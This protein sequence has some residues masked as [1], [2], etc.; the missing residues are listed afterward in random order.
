MARN[1]ISF[2]A[3]YKDGFYFSFDYNN[4]DILVCKSGSFIFKASPCN[5]V[6]KSFV[7]VGN[8]NN[9]MLNVGSSNSNVSDESCL[10][11]YISSQEWGKTIAKLQKDGI[12]ESFNLELNDVCE[13]CSLGNMTKAPFT[14]KFKP[15]KDLLE[16]IHT[17][18][19][20][21]SNLV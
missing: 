7:C 1:I 16:L 12:L 2:H 14:G 5:G 11:H 17:N 10:W 18:N 4:G 20:D 9:L 15:G 8:T 13:S 6:Y 19:V 3:L 21:C